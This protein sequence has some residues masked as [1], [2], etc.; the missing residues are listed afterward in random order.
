M[1]SWLWIVCSLISA[2]SQRQSPISSPKTFA[3]EPHGEC[4][5]RRGVLE[6]WTY[7]SL[8][9]LPAQCIKWLVSVNVEPATA[10]EVLMI[11]LCEQPPLLCKSCVRAFADDEILT[12]L[13][14]SSRLWT[15]VYWNVWMAHITVSYRSVTCL[16]PCQRLDLLLAAF[17]IRMRWGTIPYLRTRLH[18]RWDV[19]NTHT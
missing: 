1:R 15:S 18:L 19:E 10:L 16:L 12:F 5:R 7:G 13:P 4:S 6:R 17:H 9:R 8:R 2:L 3:I 14:K 11:N